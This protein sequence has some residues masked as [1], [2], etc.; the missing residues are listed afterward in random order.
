M[1]PQQLPGVERLLPQQAL[2]SS[3]VSCIAAPNVPLQQSA[4]ML[5]CVV[6]PEALAKN[7]TH[8]AFSELCPAG[9]TL[10][11]LLPELLD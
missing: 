2:Q 4:P 7:R 5:A 9:L 1:L 8:Q 3:T 11:E 6:P 10:L